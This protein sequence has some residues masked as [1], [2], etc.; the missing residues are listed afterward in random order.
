MSAEL[1]AS[2]RATE[3]RASIEDDPDPGS[4]K[5]W[6]TKGIAFWTL[7][8]AVLLRAQPRSILELGGGRSTTVLADYAFRADIPCVTI[9][10]SPI[11]RKKILNDLKFLHIGG[12]AVH[13]VP[14]VTRPGTTF[15]W[16]DQAKVERI[17]A[18]RAFD[19]VFVDGPQGNARRNADGMLII[20]QAARKARLLIVDDLHRPYNLNF[21]YDLAERCPPEGRFFLS[22]G[23]NLVGLASGV[24]AE[25]L[26]SSFAFLDLPVLHQPPVI[27]E[28]ADD[29]GG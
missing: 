25:I 8:G 17:I 14:I 28:R 13:H 23:G 1:V 4:V 7:L 20:R 18:G 24:H 6:G 22:Y 15:P 21:F 2:N 19:C 12:A 16:Y 9:E 26:R 3:Q 5:I 10:Q 29:D 27:T 11:W